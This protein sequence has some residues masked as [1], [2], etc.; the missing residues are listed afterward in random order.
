MIWSHRLITSAVSTARQS[1]QTKA[2]VDSPRHS[3]PQQQGLCCR[4]CTYTKSYC[5]PYNPPNIRLTQRVKSS[6]RFVVK[7]LRHTVPG[8]LTETV[9]CNSV[10]A[11]RLSLGFRLASITLVGGC[12]E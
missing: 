2:L 5:C 12:L 3:L 9:S 10:S 6:K 4:T 7:E 1:V 11:L 8:P